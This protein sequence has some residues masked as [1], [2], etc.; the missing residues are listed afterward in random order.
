MLLFHFG[1]FPRWFKLPAHLDY[2]GKLSLIEI[3]PILIILIDFYLKQKCCQVI[4]VSA[5]HQYAGLCSRCIAYLHAVVN[6]FPPN[7][8]MPYCMF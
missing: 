2:E 1:S 6:L 7:G 3:V 5:L 4:V 8:L